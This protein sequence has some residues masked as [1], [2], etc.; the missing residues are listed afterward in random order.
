MPVLATKLHVPA[1][2]PDLVVRPRLQ[3]RLDTAAAVPTRMLLVCAPAGF[4]KTTVISQWLATVSDASPPWRA[5]WVS[6]D[7]QDDDVRRFLAHVVAALRTTDRDVG[8]EAEAV[9]E[10]GDQVS[11]EAVLTSL[12]NDLDVVAEPTVLALDDYHE[13]TAPAVHEALAFLLEHLPAHVRVA[14]ATRSDP[15][16]PLARLRSNGALVELRAADLRFTAEETDTLLNQVMGLGVAP[17]DVASLDERTEGWAAGL[18]LAGLSMRGRR[19]VAAFVDEFTGSHRFVLD[20]L[21]EEVLSRQDDEVRDFLLRTSLLGSMTASLC[22][23]LTGRRDAQQMLLRLERDNLFVVPLDDHREWYR[24]HHLFS[25]ALQ[26]RLRAG[27]P[28]EL[29]VLHGEAS[30]WYAQHRLLSDAISHAVAAGDV[31][32]AADL[33]E[34]DLPRLRRERRDDTMRRLVRGLPD[35]VL[36]ARPLL[37]TATAWSHL[38]QGDL[39]AVERWLDVAEAALAGRPGLPRDLREWLPV[40]ADAL[41][42]D[43]REL[44]GMIS[45]YRASVAQARGDVD[46]T[47]TEARHALD[48]AGPD[49]HITRGAAL[50]FLGLAAWAADDLATAVTTFGEAVQ[51]MRAAGL[52]ADELGSTVALAGMWLARGR[53]DEARRLYERAL[54][55]AERHPL[56]LST[57][58]DL[59]VGLADVLREQGQL[60][61]ASK[62]L[63][64]ARELGD[65]ASLPENRHRWFTTAAALLRAEGDLDAALAMLDRAKAAYQPG[66]FPAVRPIPALR[67]RVQIARGDLVDAARW[68]RECGV[69]LSRP[70]TYLAEFDQLTLARLV[71]AERR[72]GAERDVDAV[73]RLLDEVVNASA[74]AGRKGSV[75][76]ARLVRSLAHAAE[77]RAEAAADDLAAALTAGVPVGY[78]RLFLDEGQPVLELLHALVAGRPGSEAA[79]FARRLLDDGPPAVTPQPAR[80]TPTLLADETL[81]DRELQVLRLLATDLSGPAIARELFV[82]VNTLR[83]HTKH[84]FT[85]LGVNSRRAAVS[86]AAELGIL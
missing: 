19:D 79:A 74:A 17:Q 41:D 22:E 36:A 31:E 63:G 85:K 28:D 18:Q 80:A 53:P 65:V 7:S 25:D 84:V 73:V 70:P 38:A 52:V 9:L 49:D 21:V 10:S 75:V 72:A 78:R 30:R 60:D 5:A 82:S 64:T 33:V 59:H 16:L 71:L 8:Q 4:G 29:A 46:R 57:T 11:T 76:E 14:L 26:A 81:S 48:Q 23:A 12:V 6:L 86:R 51:S 43:V 24:Y 68:A 56:P 55:V 42:Q 62:H 50:G 54:E 32:G 83:T 35:D 44:P 20:Y 13:I 69:A 47:V 3:R 37:A 77:G 39:D 2:R 40:E 34:L 45:V 1:P 58:G 27:H 61:A 66:F 15:P 67:A